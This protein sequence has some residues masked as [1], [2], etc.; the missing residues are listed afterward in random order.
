MLYTTN[1]IN[2]HKV[3]LLNLAEELGNDSK[4]YKMMGFSR[5]RFTVIKSWLKMAVL[6]H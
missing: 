6:M 5:I 2:K 4:A 1:P 3:G